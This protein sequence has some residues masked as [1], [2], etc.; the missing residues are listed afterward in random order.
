MMTPKSFFSEAR[1]RAAP[2]RAL[3]KP[4]EDFFL[5][6]VIPLHLDLSNLILFRSDQSCI[7]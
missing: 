3:S 6:T 5:V 7:L 2:S 4:I 1:V